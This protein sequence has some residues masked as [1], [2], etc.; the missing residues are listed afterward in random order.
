MVWGAAAPLEASCE[1]VATGQVDKDIGVLRWTYD[2]SMD[3]RRK[4]VKLSSTQMTP[5]STPPRQPLTRAR[6]VA[7]GVALADAE[8]LRG[9]SMQRLAARLGVE[10]MSLYNHVKNKEALLDGMVDH[11]V[12]EIEV[13]RV[14]G[15]WRAAMEKRAHDAHAMLLRHR[16]APLLIVS[17]VNVGPAML[18][19]VDA[20]IGCLIG[21]GF[22]YELADRAWNAID[23]HIYGFTLQEQNF[24]FEPE[25][26]VSAARA[27]LPMIPAAQ[28]PHL[29]GMSMN[30]IEGH[31]DGIQDFAFGL[32]LILEGLE[33]R[34]RASI[35]PE[36]NRDR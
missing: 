1:V 10:A 17:R 30:L 21:A 22:S 8:G 16:W 13:P 34:L 2:V 14:G 27:F 20:T 15:D 12:A 23:N 5:K 26:Y 32:S 25:E 35:R 29:H 18:R 7:E 33:A 3:I 28:Y 11:V 19:Y 6:I 36:A 4:S 31:H 9:L 24:P